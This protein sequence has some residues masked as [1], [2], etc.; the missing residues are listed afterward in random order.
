[1]SQP[2]R[3]AAT[4]DGEMWERRKEEERGHGYFFF[5][6][7]LHIEQTGLLFAFFLGFLLQCRGLVEPMLSFLLLLLMIFD[8]NWQP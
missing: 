8:T 1:M 2:I 5:L 7:L 3:A 4:V 6:L